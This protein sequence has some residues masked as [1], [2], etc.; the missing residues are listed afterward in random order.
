M[1]FPMLLSAVLK[2]EEA[3]IKH[4]INQKGQR[5]VGANN[6]IEIIETI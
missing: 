2:L 1:V 6:I 4:N 5:G 3:G